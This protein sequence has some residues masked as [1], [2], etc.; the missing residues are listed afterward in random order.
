MGRS[1]KCRRVCAEPKNRRFW[2][3]QPGEGCVT[4]PIEELEAL[5]LCDLEGLGQDEAAERMGVSRGTLQRIL[6]AARRKTAE[7]L[8]DGKSILIAGGYYELAQDACPCCNP[9]Q[10]CRWQNE[11]KNRANKGDGS[12]ER[13]G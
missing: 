6:Y 1:R 13:N 8:W 10:R 3:E 2:P 9:C 12:D 4:L 11:P 7:A 5:R